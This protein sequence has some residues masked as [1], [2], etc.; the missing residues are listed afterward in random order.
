MISALAMAAAT[1]A[2]CLF[3]MPA[4]PTGWKPRWALWVLGASLGVGLGLALTSCLYFVLL[5]V[6]VAS[7]LLAIAVTL[8]SAIAWYW[9]FRNKRSTVAC[10]PQPV[11]RVSLFAGT[12][13]WAWPCSF[14]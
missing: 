5:Q 12:A 7:P 10:A 13:S 2:G 1:A 9:W 4:L 11:P 14:K 8:A 6:S 3:V